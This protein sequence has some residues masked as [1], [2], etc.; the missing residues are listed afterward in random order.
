MGSYMNEF[1]KANIPT[2]KNNPLAPVA[3]L[4]F[5]NG[6]IA[7]LVDFSGLTPVPAGVLASDVVL[8]LREPRISLP[9]FKGGLSMLAL[10]TM[11]GT[12]G[13]STGP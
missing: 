5:E 1:T 11:I 12:T 8:Y 4:A 10:S 3:R 6:A 7:G 9:F 13:V 2:P